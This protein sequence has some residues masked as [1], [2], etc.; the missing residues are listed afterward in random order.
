MDDCKHDCYYTKYAHNIPPL[1]VHF[2]LPVGYEKPCTEQGLDDRAIFYGWN[3]ISEFEVAQIQKMRDECINQD[4]P[5]PANFGEREILKF[6]KGDKFVI[7][8]ASTNLICHLKW[9]ANLL[10][11]IELTPSILKLLHSGVY[12]LY[13]RDKYYRPIMIQDCGIIATLCASEPDICN[14]DNMMMLHEFYTQYCKQVLFLPGQVETWMQIVQ[15]NNM[16]MFAIPSSFYVPLL[17]YMGTNVKYLLGKTFFV[18]TSWAQRSVYNAVKWMIDQDTIQR[19]TLWAE[20]APK[21]LV[22]LVHPSQ[23]EKRF[24]GTA[25]TPRVFW[26]PMMGPDY[27]PNGDD[28]HLEKIRAEDYE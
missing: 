5:I 27:L 28:S 11:R 3:N 22:D 1:A 4:F 18:N 7:T 19:Y 10:P 14:S 16:G 23:L 12:Y 2:V 21:D 20:A 6:A 17:K 13:G 25:E 15:M 9:K 8:K 26:P 24:G